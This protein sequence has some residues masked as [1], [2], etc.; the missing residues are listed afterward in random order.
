ME[1]VRSNLSVSLSVSVAVS[2]SGILAKSQKNAQKIPLSQVA[3][4]HALAGALKKKTCVVYEK[5]YF[6]DNICTNNITS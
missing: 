3:N 5:Y 2:P 4:P 1:S 6:N